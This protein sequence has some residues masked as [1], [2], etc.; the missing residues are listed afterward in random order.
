MTVDGTWT[1]RY[2]PPVG[3]EQQA[4]LVLST[5]GTTL[6]GS[7][8]GTPIDDGEAHGTDF[9][10]TANLTSPFKVKVK[11]TGSVDGDT[12]AGK[13]KAAFMTVEFAGT[14]KAI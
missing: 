10:Y 14:R 5:S 1:V 3:G 6:T 9:S 12:I 13:V 2:Q 8:D 11:C 7:F 4:D